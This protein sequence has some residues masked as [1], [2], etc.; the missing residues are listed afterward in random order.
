MLYG[1]S[2]IE[3]KLKTR[4]DVH[5]DAKKWTLNGDSFLATVIRDK[6]S[7]VFSTIVRK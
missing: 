5:E 3:S 1:K 6:L 7:R 4:R 2:N